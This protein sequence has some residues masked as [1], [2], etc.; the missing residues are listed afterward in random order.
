MAKYFQSILKI[1]VTFT[2]LNIGNFKSDDL[3]IDYV[4]ENFSEIRESGA[5]LI[6]IILHENHHVSK[7][8]LYFKYA[9][10]W[11]NFYK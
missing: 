5:D 2:I 8:N 9:K 3:K 4:L 10:R 11:S 6:Y 1:V 7:L